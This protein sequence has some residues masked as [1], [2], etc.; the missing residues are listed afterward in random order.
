MRILFVILCLCLPQIAAAKKIKVSSISWGGATS[1][2]SLTPVDD[3]NIGFNLTTKVSFDAGWAVGQAKLVPYVTLYTQG[4]SV[5]FDYNAKDKITAGIALRYKVMRHGNLSFGVK[6]DYD[7]RPI[8]GIVYSGF[9]LTS[10]F[11]FYRVRK[12]EN[13]DRVI[14]SGWANLRYPGSASS[15]DRSNLIGQGQF[16]LAR[17]RKIGKSKYSAAGFTSFGL[18][19]DSDNNEYNNKFQLDFG[20]RAK[21]K[22]KNTDVTL[23]VKY[24]IDHRFKSEETYRGV[25]VGLSWLTIG[26]SK[27]SQKTKQKN[28]KGWLGK[29]IG[30]GG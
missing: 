5:G 17:E 29:L 12:Q 21:R 13:G 4:D 8:T 25:I 23:S 16:T 24:R 9:G 14:L 19:G 15:E 3:G 28:S 2:N 10:D 1:P 22:I 30:L 26:N 7:Y 18:V 20:L 27:P 6:Y 11:G